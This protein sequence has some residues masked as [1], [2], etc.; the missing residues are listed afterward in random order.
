MRKYHKIKTLFERDNKTKKL[1]QGKY[2]DKTIEFLKDN[3]WQFTEKVDGTNIRVHWDGHRVSFGGRKD[4]SLIPDHLMNKL[5]ELFGGAENEQLFEQKFGEN[6]VTLFGEGYGVRI[7]NGGLYRDDVDFILFDVVINDWYLTRDSIENIAEYFCIDVVPILLEGTL[8]QGISFV[9]NNRKSFIAK[10]G[11]D[12]EGIV[13]RPKQELFARNG[14]RI[15]CKI[16]YT[17]FV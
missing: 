14:E 5:N 16:K 17:D 11:A 13:G 6:E 7:Q 10:K 1:I 9:L 8:E 2:T 3:I 4:D 15:I 12:L